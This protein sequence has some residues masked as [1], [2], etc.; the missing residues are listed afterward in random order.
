M[1]SR[2]PN[3]NDV[4]ELLK[5]NSSMSVVDISEKLNLARSTVHLCINELKRR[6]WIKPRGERINNITIYDIIKKD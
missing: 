1:R 2:E 6:R 3:L 5:Q 4:F